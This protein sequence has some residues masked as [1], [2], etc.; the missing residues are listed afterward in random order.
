MKCTCGKTYTKTRQN[1]TTKYKGKNIRLIGVPVFVCEN[2][3]EKIDKQTQKRMRFDL[4]HV[5]QTGLTEWHF[6]A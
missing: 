5:Y 3:H 1:I 2:G 6:G 4:K